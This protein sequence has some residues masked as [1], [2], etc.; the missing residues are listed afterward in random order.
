MATIEKEAVSAKA[1]AKIVGT[2]TVIAILIEQCLKKQK[3][4]QYLLK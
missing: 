1:E 4:K 2:V 3:K